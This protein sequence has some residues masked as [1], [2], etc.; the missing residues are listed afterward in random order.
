MEKEQVD[1]PCCA[2]KRARQQRASATDAGDPAYPRRYVTQP[3]GSRDPDKA[4]VEGHDRADHRLEAGEVHGDSSGRRG[5]S[6][7]YRAAKTSFATEAAVTALG[8]PA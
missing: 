7:I 3:D 8:Q 5:R 2:E 6:M 1:G 4:R